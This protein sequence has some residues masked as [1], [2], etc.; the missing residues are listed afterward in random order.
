MEADGR[1]A[2]ALA[3]ATRTHSIAVAS[4]NN[5]LAQQWAT[6]VQAEISTQTLASNVQKMAN[7]SV[8]QAVAANNARST[9]MAQ[10]YA[11]LAGSAMNMASAHVQ[12]SAQGSA[13][14]TET[15][16]YEGTP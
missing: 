16:R 9:A 2:S 10:V 3:E 12:L 4:Y 11:Q 8:H 1:Y 5:V 15:W 13:Q 7:D 6:A 14:T